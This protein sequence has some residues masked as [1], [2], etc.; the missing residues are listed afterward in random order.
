VAVVAG[1][2]VVVVENPVEAQATL[3]AQ[4]TQMLEEA[5][6]VDPSLEAAVEAVVQAHEV[7]RYLS[8]G[9]QDLV[10][11]AAQLLMVVEVEGHQTS[12]PASY[13]LVVHKGVAPEMIF[14]GVG[15]QC[16]SF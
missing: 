8:P 15:K 4:A 1:E 12:R 10:A 3:E 5:V 9:P 14:S 16:K 7:L 11:K 2:V 6:V 13:S